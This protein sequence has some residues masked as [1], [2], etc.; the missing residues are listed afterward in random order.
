MKSL[1]GEQV[2]WLP[3]SDHDTELRRLADKHYSRK[4]KGAKKYIGPGE[5]LALI[6]PDGKAGF[7][8]RKTNL[9]LR[10]DAQEGIECTLFRNE[11]PELYLSSNLILEAEKLAL[12]KWP[13]AERFFTYVNP[14]KIRSTYPGFTFIKAGYEKV[15]LSKSKKLVIMAKEVKA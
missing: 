1:Y 12:Q 10:M 4:T 7:I 2:I 11:A 14:A 8:W 3:V 9:E 15:G 13:D 5:Y 6:T